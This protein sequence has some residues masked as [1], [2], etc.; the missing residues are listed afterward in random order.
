MR[1]EPPSAPATSSLTQAGAAMTRSRASPPRGSIKDRASYCR[2]LPHRPWPPLETLRRQPGW[3]QHANPW[4]DHE[5][6]RDASAGLPVRPIVPGSGS[7]CCQRD[8]RTSVRDGHWD[9]DGAHGRGTSLQGPQH[10][11]DL[12]ED[13]MP[14][15][16]LGR[17]AKRRKE[18]RAAPLRPRGGVSM[19]S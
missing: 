6:G 5:L 7:G 16:A 3:G 9:S 1:M 15:V 10:L 18:L 17:R 4:K 19:S 12:A 14:P 13:D 11:H 8:M 2:P